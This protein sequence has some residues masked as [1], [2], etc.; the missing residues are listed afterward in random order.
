[1]LHIVVG[2]FLF[3]AGLAL[4]YLAIHGAPKLPSFGSAGARA[5]PS[6][7]APVNGFTSGDVLVGEMLTE[8]MSLR[9]QLADLQ[10]QVSGS[11]G[12]SR[13]PTK[14]AS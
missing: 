11:R 10:Q 14:L 12:R 4:I 6:K 9:E 7:P 13:R 3:A 8:M 1:M 2:P 5:R